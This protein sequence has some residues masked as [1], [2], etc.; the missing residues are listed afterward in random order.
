MRVIGWLCVIGSGLALV[1]GILVGRDNLRVY[2]ELCRRGQV[3]ACGM[4]GMPAFT[5]GAVMALALL[6]FGILVLA[7]RPRRRRRD[8]YDPDDEQMRRIRRI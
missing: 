4:D 7:I 5:T 8:A 1:A 6:A 3:W 2:R